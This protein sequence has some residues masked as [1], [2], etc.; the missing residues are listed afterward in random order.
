MVNPNPA[1]ESTNDGLKFRE[2]RDQMMAVPSYSENHTK[3]HRCKGCERLS[4]ADW[5]LSHSKRAVPY[6]FE[7]EQE[8]RR[9][10]DAFRSSDAFRVP[11][12]A[13]VEMGNNGEC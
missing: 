13:L 4:D 10:T 6:S 11:N 1:H 9:Q 7:L 12:V 2:S 5:Q 8:D 3:F